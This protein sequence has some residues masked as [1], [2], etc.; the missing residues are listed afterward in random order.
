MKVTVLLMAAGFV[1]IGQGRVCAQSTGRV[2]HSVGP[3]VFTNA[4]A[5]GYADGQL[6]GSNFLCGVYAGTEV[7]SLSPCFG[8]PGSYLK[9]PF[10]AAGWAWLWG[11]LV[12]DAPAGTPILVQFRAWP[13]EFGTYEEA[14]ATGVPS[15][16]VGV[17]G[18]VPAI[19]ENLIVEFPIQMGLLWLSPVVS[20]SDPFPPLTCTLAPNSVLLSWPTNSAGL[21]LVA[22][23][24][25]ASNAV[26]SPVGGTVVVSNGQNRVSVPVANAFQFFRLRR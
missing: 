10:M 11:T 8:P 17:S 6:A 22:A 2:Y 24:A 18:I 13:A 7:N 25:L 1:L 16:P 20:A 12:V 19:P 4:A 9:R 26:W 21:V 14:L 5:W 23:S 3:A 15:P